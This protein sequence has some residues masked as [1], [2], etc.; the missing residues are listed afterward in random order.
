[1]V[2]RYGGKGEDGKKG[3]RKCKFCG[4]TNKPKMCP[5]YDQ[6]SRKCIKRNYWTACCQSKKVHK[7]K[8]YVIESITENEIAPI[9]S[10]EATAETDIEGN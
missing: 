6:E 8:T 3:A 2:A 1:M 7:T 4:R 9:H 10:C 5:A